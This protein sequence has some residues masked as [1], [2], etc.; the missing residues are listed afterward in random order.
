[1][2]L[3]CYRPLDGVP[4]GVEVRD[5]ASV[6]GE[7]KVLRYR[8]GSVALFANWFRLELQRRALGTW[9]DTDQYLIAPIPSAAPYLFAWQEEGVI[10]NSL[11][12]LPADC[13]MLAELLA[14]F[15][16]REI[17][18]WLSPPQRMAA[19]VRLWSTGR[20]GLAYMPW[21]TTGLHALTA[22]AR[23]HGLTGE[24]LVSSAFYPVHFQDA[25]WLRDPSRPLASIVA[26]DTIGVHLW[27]EKI[28]AWKEEPAPPGSF[29]ARLHEEGA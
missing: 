16:Q 23:K 13:P 4:A 27:N 17:P 12:R 5:A 18:F 26:P 19:R 20:T 7:D 11:L 6:I 1:V 21:G 15:D 25:A 2:A 24:A 10:N 9:V 8:S 14:I 29:L 22:I 3:Y 28:K